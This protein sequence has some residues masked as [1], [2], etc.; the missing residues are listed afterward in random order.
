[1]HIAKREISILFKI[2]YTQNVYQYINVLCKRSICSN[3][4]IKVANIKTHVSIECECKKWSEMGRC[5]C[6]CGSTNVRDKCL[7][8]SVK[9]T[10]LCDV[11]P[12]ILVHMSTSLHQV[13]TCLT[14]VHGGLCHKT[15]KFYAQSV[16]LS[17]S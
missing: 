17:N 12:C 14:K 4:N 13:A 1:M 5:G 8:W 11:T 16:L 7:R 9:L 2:T 3:V 15:N 6:M 10:V